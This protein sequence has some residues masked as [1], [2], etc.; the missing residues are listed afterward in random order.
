MSSTT[1]EDH[2]W[3]NPYTQECLSVVPDCSSHHYHHYQ[4]HCPQSTVTLAL[5]YS[6]PQPSALY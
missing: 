2:D 1:L 3:Y 5:P 4:F 6:S